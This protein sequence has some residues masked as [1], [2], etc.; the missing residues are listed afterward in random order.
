[1]K[2]EGWIGPIRERTGNGS[3]LYGIEYRGKDFF[4]FE[5]SPVGIMRSLGIISRNVMDIPPTI[6][7]LAGIKVADHARTFREANR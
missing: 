2:G 1:M 6:K 5:V 7:S 4:R 3:V